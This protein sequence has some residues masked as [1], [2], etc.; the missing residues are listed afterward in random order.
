MVATEQPTWDQ[1]VEPVAI[2]APRPLLA[3]APPPEVWAPPP[4][5]RAAEVGAES[6]DAPP[7]LL[8]VHERLESSR[9]AAGPQAKRRIVT[10][11]LDSEEYEG[12]E[13]DVWQNPPFSLVN[14]FQNEDVGVRLRGVGKLMLATNNWHNPDGEPYPAPTDP[15]FWDGP[16]CIPIDLMRLVLDTISGLLTR[17]PNS[18]RARRPV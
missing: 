6:D 9:T 3:A 4:P 2:P 16:N 10:L 12:F 8:I 18:R 14:T 15:A 11:T 7:R 1:R 17:N 13:M 5:E